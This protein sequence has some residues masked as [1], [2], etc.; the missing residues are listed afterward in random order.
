[1]QK[2]DHPVVQVSWD[3]AVAYAAW[4][5]SG[6]ALAAAHRG[7]G[8]RL[9]PRPNGRRRR[10]E[11]RRIYPWGDTFDQAR[12]NTSESK[13][14]GTTA[15]GSYPGGASPYGAPRHGG[16]RLGVDAQS[17]Q[18]LSLHPSD[19]REANNSTESRVLR[20]GSWCAPTPRSRARPVA[21]RLAGQ[22]LRQPHWVPSRCGSGGWFI[23]GG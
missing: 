7:G 16:Q 22:L 6:A 17:L 5:A 18:V 10:G 8:E 13:R 1:M 12:A 23:A 3:D 11:R 19:G 21:P 15:V 20:G 4:L 9:Q 2:L 14:G